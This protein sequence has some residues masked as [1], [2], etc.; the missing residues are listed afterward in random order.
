MASRPD[1]A[2]RNKLNATHGMTKSTTWKSW[3]AMR[4]RCLTPSHK[5]YPRY[6][7]VGITVCQAWASSFE[8][9][10][11]DMGE[12]PEGTSIDRIDGG[13]GYEPGNC[14]WATSKQQ[15]NNKKSNV[16]V[17]VDGVEKTIA[18][19]SEVCGVERKT[20]EYR[21]R[22]GWDHKKAV[23]TPSLIKRK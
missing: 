20:L 18:E 3:R 9:F 8:Q 23:T 1:L 5:D 16:L 15:G 21:I 13:K 19:W 17:C 10:L 22:T 4:E 2:L 12:R 7:A 14:R 6:G 11:S